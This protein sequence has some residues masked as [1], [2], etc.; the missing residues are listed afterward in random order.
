MHL[1]KRGGSPAHQRIIRRFAAQHAR[2]TKQLVVISTIPEGVSGFWREE[3]AASPVPFLND[4]TALAALRSLTVPV[5]PDAPADIVVPPEFETVVKSKV[6][7]R[8][9]MA[10]TRAQRQ[11]EAAHDAGQ[12]LFGEVETYQLL[13]AAGMEVAPYER[14]QSRDEAVAAANRLGYPVVL[15]LSAAGVT[16]KAA[17]GLVRLDLRTRDD[18]ARA[19]DALAARP[20]P[21]GARPAGAIVQ[22]M[23]RSGVELL[24]GMRADAHFGPVVTVGLGGVWTEAMRDVQL[25]LA[26]MSADRARA[27]LEGLRARGALRD[28]AAQARIDIEAIAAAVSRFSMLAALIAPPVTLLEINPLIATPRGCVAVDALAQLSA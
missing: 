10:R 11:S 12:V 6:L 21:P 19:Y 22:A 24:L 9:E 25:G 13:E 8:I 20:Q 5:A 1:K 27:L 18:V 26:P 15:K 4:L 7:P 23:V 2:A 3:S 16:H 17:A 14:V 28:A